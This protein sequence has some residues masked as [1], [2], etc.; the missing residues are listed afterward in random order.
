[1]IEGNHVLSE[2]NA[3]LKYLCE[4]KDSVPET[5]WPKDPKLRS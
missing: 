4:S 2:S 3:I 5:Y 1:M